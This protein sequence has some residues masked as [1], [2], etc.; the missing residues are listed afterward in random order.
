MRKRTTQ[1]EIQ[2]NI[3]YAEWTNTTVEENAQVR[4]LMKPTDKKK[5]QLQPFKGKV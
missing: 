3:P 1:T 2:E 4:I 5:K